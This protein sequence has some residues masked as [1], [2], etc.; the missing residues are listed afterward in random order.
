VPTTAAA[1]RDLHDNRLSH[2][3]ADLYPDQTAD[4]SVPA[5]GG[6]GTISFIGFA[7]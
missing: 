6:Y 3:S 4:K 5:P 7:G 1:P 2:R